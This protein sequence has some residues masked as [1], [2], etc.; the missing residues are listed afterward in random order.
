MRYYAQ[1]QLEDLDPQ[2]TALE[3]IERVAQPGERSRMRSLLGSFL[4]RA[5]EVDKR[6]SV[7][8]GGENFL[9]LKSPVANALE[10]GK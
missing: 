2:A 9:V 10:K 8:S 1:H 6:V 5:D 4:F 3:E 7:L